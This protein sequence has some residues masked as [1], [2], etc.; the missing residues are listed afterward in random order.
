MRLLLIG[1]PAD[2]ARA[3]KIA[4]EGGA[5]YVRTPSLRSAIALVATA[6]FLFTPDTSIAH[7]ASAFR[8]PCV[9][10]HPQGMAAR[11]AL[12]HTIGRTLEHT[13]YSLASFPV[14]RAVAAVDEVWNEAGISRRN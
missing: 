10:M 7:A 9:A 4:R 14:S 5:E 8:I 6:E 13:E 2:V 12:W 11:W 1:A 3:Q